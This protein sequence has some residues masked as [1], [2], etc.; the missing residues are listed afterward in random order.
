MQRSSPANAALL[1]AP[2][3]R[4]R[5]SSYQRRG[6][7][8]AGIGPAARLPAEER[9]RKG[10]CSWALRRA[11]AGDAAGNV[12]AHSRAGVHDVRIETRV[13]TENPIRTCRAKNRLLWRDDRVDLVCS[14]GAGLAVQV[15]EPA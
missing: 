2:P 1:N 13:R 10:S 14:G 6:R 8:A 12:A 3:C 11:A 15:E 7:A 4:R 5:R 9:A